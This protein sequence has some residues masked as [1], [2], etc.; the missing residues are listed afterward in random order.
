MALSADYADLVEYRNVVTIV[1]DRIKDLIDRGM[2][3]AQV[4]AANPTKGFAKRYGADSGSWTTDDVRRS[5]VHQ[6]D[7]EEIAH[8]GRRAA[9][10]AERMTAARALR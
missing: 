8:S 3:L 9:E 7:A 2:T 1:R 4:K 10:D 6:L 5:R